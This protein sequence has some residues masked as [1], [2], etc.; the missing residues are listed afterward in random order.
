[1]TERAEETLAELEARA[2][3]NGHKRTRPHAQQMTL[4]G[5]PADG[6][7]SQV[8]DE[9]LALDVTAL[10]PIEALTRLYELQQKG[11]GET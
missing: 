3:Q 2:R 11:R 8:L 5:G 4:F 6:V 7:A 10:T 1:V 9:L